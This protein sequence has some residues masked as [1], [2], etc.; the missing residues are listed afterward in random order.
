V[1]VR[2]LVCVRVGVCV[3]VRVHVQTDRQ[4]GRHRKQ[5]NCPCDSSARLGGSGLFQGTIAL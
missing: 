4:T 1:R 2:V 5:A 3:R